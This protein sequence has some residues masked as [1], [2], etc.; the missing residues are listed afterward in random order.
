MVDVARYFT[1]FLTE[2][3]CGKCVPCREG[4]MQMLKILERICAGEGRS[5]DIAL[6]EELSETILDTSLCALGSTAPNP[7]LSTIKYFRNEYEAHIKDKKCPARVCKDLITFT[8]IE[9]NCVGCQACFKA[10]PVNAIEQTD[11]PATIKGKVS[12]K[13]KI[14]R[15]IQEKCIKCGMCYESCKFNAIKVE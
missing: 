8:V 13:L 9:E 15:V 10:C 14:H 4:V 6:L 7:V 12:P 11:K 2:E 1:K 5:D 3:S